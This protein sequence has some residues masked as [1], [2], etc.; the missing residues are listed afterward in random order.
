MIEKRAVSFHEFSG[1]AWINDEPF[2]GVFRI[3][4]IN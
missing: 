3:I 2:V 1:E 4:K